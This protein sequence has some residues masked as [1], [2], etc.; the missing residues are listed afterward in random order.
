MLPRHIYA[1]DPTSDYVAYALIEMAD[2]CRHSVMFGRAIAKLGTRPYSSGRHRMLLG[3]YAAHFANAAEIFT[4]TLVNEEIF[5]YFNRITVQDESVQPLIRRIWEIHI[6]EES[7]HVS[8][9]HH[10]MTRRLEQLS[11]AKAAKYRLT[12]GLSAYTVTTNLVSPKVYVD[13]GLDPRETLAER[14]GSEHYAATIRRAAAKSVKHVERFG[15]LKGPGLAFWRAA[16]L[17]P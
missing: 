12:L 10:E 13:C 7:R 4:L 16:R 5:D 14:R 9:A 8:Y 3:R 15:L 17:L 2:E 1:M 6:A 11:R